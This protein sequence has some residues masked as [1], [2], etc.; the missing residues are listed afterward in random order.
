MNRFWPR[1][2]LVVAALA[3]AAALLSTREVAAQTPF[4]EYP[5]FE[6]ADAAAPIPPD[7]NIPAEFVVG[8]L[9]Y[10]GGRFGFGGDWRQGGTS[11]TD[12]YPKGDRT[13]IGMLRRFTRTSVRGVEQPIN[14]DDD[15]DVYYYPFMVVGLAS[16]WQL[17]DSQA[18]KL[19]E[20]LLRGGFLFCDSFFGERNWAVF[21]ESLKRVFP[22]RPIIDMTDDHPIFH[23]VFDLPEMT[24][25]QI[26]NANSI[27][28]GGR[29]MRG[30]PRWRGVEDDNGR[31][32][33]LIAYNNDVM[34]GWQ[35][36]DDP[37]YPGDKANLALRLGVNVAMYALTH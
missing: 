34:D 17:T 31:L 32:M 10:P 24:K 3:V 7:W 5:S 9:M 27:G 8:R 37:R 25:V 12:D 33:I 20:Y 23:V 13:F 22:D 2:L 18:A 14:P 26:P 6:G 4:R 1:A 29:G 16:A 21:E 35:W 28:W 30:T 19:R 36:A 11:W 15:G